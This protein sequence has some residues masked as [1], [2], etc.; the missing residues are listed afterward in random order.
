MYF[1]ITYVTSTTDIMN[2][3]I[4]DLLLRDM[5]KNLRNSQTEQFE[6]DIEITMMLGNDWISQRQHQNC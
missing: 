6:C 1:N 4:R 3:E 2:D 5:N